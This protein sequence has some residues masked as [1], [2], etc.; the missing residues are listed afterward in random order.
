MLHSYRGG[1]SDNSPFPEIFPEAAL[2]NGQPG[3]NE[4]LLTQSAVMQQ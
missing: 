2:A 4:C 1:C 3:P